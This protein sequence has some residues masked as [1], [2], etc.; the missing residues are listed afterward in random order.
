MDTATQSAEHAES[1]SG[2]ARVWRGADFRRLWVG[3]TISQLGTQVTVVVLPLIAVVSLHATVA[4]MGFLSTAVRVPYLLYLVAGVWVDRMR[5]RPLLVG[6]DLSRGVLLLLLPVAALAHVLSLELLIG[7]IFAVM[8]IGVWFDIAYLSYVPALV[9]REELTSAN[10]ITETSNSLAQV[11]GNSV[12]GFLVQLLTAPIAILADSLSYFI[13]AALVWRIRKPEPAAPPRQGSGIRDIGRS[14]AAGARY[15]RRHR[16][17]APLALAIG[18]NNVF[19]AAELA[20]FVFYLDR[21]LHLGAGLIG[22]IFAAGGPGAVAGSALAGKAQRAVG[23]AGAIIGGLTLFAVSALAIPFVPEQK[24]VAVPVLMVATF[25][26]MA[27][28]QICSINVITARQTM[29]PTEY[30]GRINASFRFMAL[31]TSPFG[32]LLGG[33]LGSTLGVR[34]GILAA[35]AGMF[36]APALV[37]L[38]PVRRLRTLPEADETGAAA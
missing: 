38:S 32:S 1:G 37:W 3:Q 29:A 27:G 14:I 13:S 12:A 6:T 2:R 21:Q 5:R 15:I 34:D 9:D 26:M 22:L 16:F 28:G 17:L 23:V 31:G 20:Q 11:A 25:F 35:V 8:V 24:L 33:L 19:Y 10:T 30:L 36:L 4:D 7:V 18:I